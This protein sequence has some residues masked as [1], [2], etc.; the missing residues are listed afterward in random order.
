[1]SAVNFHSDLTN[2]S[3][4][5]HKANIAKD[6]AVAAK[7]DAGKLSEALKKLNKAHGD[8]KY[9]ALE[10]PAATNAK[11]LEDAVGEF[12]A[13]VKGS[14]KIIRDAAR[15]SGDAA[16]AFAKDAQKVASSFKGDSNKLV[17]TEGAA[18][19]AVSKAA[20]AFD[21]D[22]VKTIDAARADL[23]ARLKQ[24]RE[25]EKK[26][27]GA[28][29]PGGKPVETKAGKLVRTRALE[30]IRK[31]KKPQPGARPFRF[32]V[33]AGKASVTV[34]MGPIASTSQEK[35]LK[36][37][38]PTEKPYKVYKDPKGE[39]I[40]EKN[41]ITLVSDRLPMGLAKKMQIWLKKLTKLN[42]KIRIRKTTGEVDESDEGEDIKDDQLQPDAADAADAVAK[43]QAGKDFAKRLDSMKGDIKAAASGP[44][45]EEIR[46]LIASI[47]K[48]GNA[49]DFEEADSQLDE[50]EA[51]LAEAAEAEKSAPKI[52]IAEVNKAKAAWGGART[53]A[54]SGIKDLASEIGVAFKDE[55][56]QKAKVGEAVTRLYGLIPK[57][58][59]TLEAQLDA[60]VGEKDPAKQKQ[61]VTR[62][63]LT[64]DSL[65]KL[66]DEDEL[67]IN[68]DD[69]EVKKMKIVETMRD[70]L[71]EVE[72]ALG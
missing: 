45:S 64:V 34:Y 2:A 26:G 28:P 71:S 14:L 56:A 42:A 55:T 58:G 5:K 54:I 37:L 52:S 25:K 29:A 16:D 61:L 60:A 19:T 40:W 24:A 27:A 8:F 48:A 13:L 65:S 62:A 7:L 21:K 31:I 6:K 32:V 50:M 53:Q 10:F 46:E 51:L 70:R 49:K 66:L 4:D 57:L 1:M 63:K 18:A 38:I 39:V 72:A 9:E 3:W 35:L 67:F 12:E 44:M 33:V 20:S 69:N 43:K 41:A 68:I 23:D 15:T 59:T 11:Q 47:T 17:T 22:I 36:G 30:C